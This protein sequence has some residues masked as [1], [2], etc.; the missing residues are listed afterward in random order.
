MDF[1]HLIHG[2]IKL[3]TTV[4][5]YC[6]ALHDNDHHWLC[7]YHYVAQIHWYTI[8]NV[9]HLVFSITSICL[10]KSITTTTTNPPN[11]NNKSVKTPFSVSWR[12]SSRI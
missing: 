10:S 2:F 5:G 6:L 11:T 9:F 1:Y 7:V 4:N 12:L 3:S 8:F